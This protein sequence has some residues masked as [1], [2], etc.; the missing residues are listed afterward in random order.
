VTVGIDEARRKLL[1]SAFRMPSPPTMVSRK[2][3]I[4]NAFV[5]AIIPVIEP[6]SEEIEEALKILAIDPADLQCAYCG[7]RATEWDHL[8]PLVKHRRPTGFISEIG[9]LVPSCGKCNQSKGNSEWERWMRSAMAKWSPTSRKV[10]ETETRI[11]RLRAYECWRPAPPVDFAS[12]VG[13]E[14]WEAYWKR[15]EAV[16]AMLAECQGAAAELGGK[17]A[18]A[19]HGRK[20][21]ETPASHAG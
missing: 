1:R 6:S 11:E 16:D 12:I 15:L 3:T 13:T 19:R 20:R 4:T 5:C 10:P 7:A 2:S 18:E 14:A 9:N 17:I 21:T 8:R